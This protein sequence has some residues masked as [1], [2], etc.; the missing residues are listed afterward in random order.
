LDRKLQAEKSSEILSSTPNPV[1]MLSYITNPPGSRD[2]LKIT[3]SGRVKDIEPGDRHRWCEY[4]FYRGVIRLGYARV[5]HG[6]LSDTEVQ[7]GK[8]RIP[9]YPDEPD[10]EIMTQSPNEV[11][12][13]TH[14]PSV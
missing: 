5:S 12:E 8:F 11:P 14:F 4:I 13:W 2:Y 9:D 3:N 10:Y 7:I 6:G 1:I